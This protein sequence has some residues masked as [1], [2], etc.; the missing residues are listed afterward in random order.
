MALLLARKEGMAII[1][2]INVAKSLPAASMPYWANYFIF[3]GPQ[4][5][6]L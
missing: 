6:Y 4:F 1:E 2:A 5:S 3:F